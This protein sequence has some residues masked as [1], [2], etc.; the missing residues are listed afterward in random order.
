MLYKVQAMPPRRRP[1]ARLLTIT[2]WSWLA[3]LAGLGL[4]AA[5]AIAWLTNWPGAH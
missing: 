3:A 5:L 2:G 4:A 1:A